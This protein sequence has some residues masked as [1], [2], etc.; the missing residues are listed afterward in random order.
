MA[1]RADPERIFQ[2][3]NAATIER[4]VGEGIPRSMVDAWIESYEGGDADM[5]RA[6]GD[7]NFWQN[8]HHYARGEYDPRHKPPPPPDTSSDERD[9]VL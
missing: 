3:K 6:R 2:A 8:A 1:G 9:P 7:P 4:L 5:H